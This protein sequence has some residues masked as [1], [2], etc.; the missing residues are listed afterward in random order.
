MKLIK[1][2]KTRAVIVGVLILV[3][4]AVIASTITDSKVIVVSLEIISGL[5]VIGIAVL[6][7]ELFKDKSR[8]LV[9]SYLGLKWIEGLMMIIAGLLFIS[10]AKGIPGLREMIYNIHTYIFILSAILFY[11][12][13]FKT[14][15]IPRFISIWGVIACILLLIGNLL[16][17]T[18][19]TVPAALLA[20]FYGPIILNE[21]FISI[22][23]FVKGFKK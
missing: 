10:S 18:G 15:V 6:M 7:S 22:W 1:S 20:L 16:D 17:L 5:S 3:A 9:L 19:I 11:I 23:L 4:Y 12:L 21:I 13:L 2:E 14:S 8:T